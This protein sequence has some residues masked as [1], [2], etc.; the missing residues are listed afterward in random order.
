MARSSLLETSLDVNTDDG[1][2]LLSIVQGEQLEYPVTLS[3]LTNAGAGYTYEAVII[4]ALNVSGSDA[5]PT[6]ARPGGVLTTLVVRVP[7]ERGDWNG[8][9]AYNREDVVLYSLV[10]YKLRSG[11]ARV[12]ATPPSSDTTYWEEYLPNKVFIQ[13]EKTLT[14]TPTWAVLPT[15]VAPVYGY[16][17][18][19]VA[20][21]AGGVYPRTWKPLRGLVCFEYSPTQIVPD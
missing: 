19:R 12:N 18:L 20:E 11:T 21:P 14:L 10:Y 1:S 6:V 5:V 15:I 16:F 8:A 4:E 7:T 3:F 2:V 13:F 9:T 17:E